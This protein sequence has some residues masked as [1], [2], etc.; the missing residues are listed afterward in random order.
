MIKKRLKYQYA[1]I[2]AGIVFVIPLLLI[3]TL[4]QTNL[5]K[6]PITEPDY[7]FDEVVEPSLP[8]VNTTT[9]IINPYLDNSVTIGKKYYDYKGEEDSQINS[10]IKHDNTYLQNTG[11]DFISETTF[12]VISILDGTVIETTEDDISG[13]TVEIKHNNG[14]T[15]IY[16]S[17]SEVTVKK[18]EKVNQGQI[19]GK[20]GTTEIDK[21]LGNHLHFEMYEN[22][23]AVNPENYLNKE[24]P[25]K[26]EN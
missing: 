23:G 15:S 19:L 5:K 24:V 16:K 9:R 20:S 26:E 14:Y 25:L 12:D 13:K 11:I 4:V 6:E 2:L 1:F 8:V 22:G 17:L 18:G 7:V 10:I 21:D 3:A